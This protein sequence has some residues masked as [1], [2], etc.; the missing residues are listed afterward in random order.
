[1]KMIY[2]D[3]YDGVRPVRKSDERGLRMFGYNIL[4]NT[5][6]DMGIDPTVEFLED[7]YSKDY[8]NRLAAYGDLLTMGKVPKTRQERF[9]ANID[10]YLSE[11]EDGSVRFCR[12]TKAVMISWAPE[13]AR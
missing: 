3:L 2:E 1:M 12:P 7:G 6:Y 10:R 11:N 4:F 9:F 13:Q 5:L 8:A